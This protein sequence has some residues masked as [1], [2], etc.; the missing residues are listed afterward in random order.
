MDERDDSAIR[1]TGDIRI[2]RLLQAV[3]II[4]LPVLGPSAGALLQSGPSFRALAS[5][6]VVA[7][8]I[9][10]YLLIVYQ[11]GPRGSFLGSRA[12]SSD[13]PSTQRDRAPLNRWLPIGLLVA[14]DVVLIPADGSPWLS[15]IIFTC[16]AMAFRL[17]AREAAWA[18]P[19]MAPLA[20]ALG[21]A[22]RASAQDIGQA[23]MIGLS[24]GVGVTSA[25]YA[26]ATMRELRVARGE[27]ARL[28]V[29]EERLRFA[30]DL[31]D[32][33]GHSLSLVAL[34]TELAGRLIDH[35]PDRAV[36]ELRDVESVARTALREVREAVAGYRQPTLASEMAAAAE[37][38]AAAGIA[39]RSEGEP[40]S[41]PPRVEAALAWTLREGV[42]NVIRHSRARSC[43]V[44]FTHEADRIAIAVVDDG[45][46]APV[47]AAHPSLAA[48]G[49]RSGLAGLTERVAAIGGTIDSGPLPTSGFRLLATVPTASTWAD[50]EAAPRSEITSIVVGESS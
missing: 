24:V 21:I 8:Y 34:K 36:D 28:A 33:L 19:A 50:G 18:L 10:T 3:S 49:G 2:T 25:F 42:T 22:A 41:P 46:G 16:V 47:D 37:I 17:K 43:T 40:G 27:L 26:F 5:L 9:V 44:R 13:L 45:Q 7:L 23:C 6:A 20:I 29:A 12:A 48:V 15:L 11:C 32:L 14:I 1:S 31:H 4:W 30:R 39:F 38:L 35:A